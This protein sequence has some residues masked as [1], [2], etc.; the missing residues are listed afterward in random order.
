MDSTGPPS[1]ALVA[2][3]FQ[4]LC[5]EQEED[6]EEEETPRRAGPR[7]GM[8]SVVAALLGNVSAVHTMV[9]SGEDMPVQAPLVESGVHISAEEHAIIPR[10][11]SPP[12]EASVS[13]VDRD[14]LEAV[15]EYVVT[16]RACMTVQWRDSWRPASVCPAGHT[17]CR[18]CYAMFM[19]PKPQCP[20]CRRDIFRITGQS[21]SPVQLETID[22]AKYTCPVCLLVLE[23][24]AAGCPEG[25]LSCRQCLL[26]NKVKPSTLNPQPS[27]LNLKPSTSNPQPSTLNPTTE[28]L[29]RN[30]QPS[31]LNPT[32]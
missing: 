30:P 20:V 28:T 3:A 22:K 1:P 29:K 27:T 23:H 15:D 31:T 19:W 24:P 7:L 13:G 6:G 18:P 16:C 4:D 17:L 2:R 10:A 21:I 12:R 32:S 5:G 11:S 26:D 25:H 8:A 9:A 14:W